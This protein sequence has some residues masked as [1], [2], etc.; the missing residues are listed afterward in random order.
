[1]NITNL[2]SKAFHVTTAKLGVVN[3]NKVNQYFGRANIENIHQ[4]KS[5]GFVAGVRFNVKQLDMG[6]A[7]EIAPDGDRVVTPRENKRR[8]G[9]VVIGSRIDV[10]SEELAEKLPSNESV[11]V[12][13]LDGM[14]VLLPRPSDVNNQKRIDRLKESLELNRFETAAT[15]SGV[16]TLDDSLHEGFELN[17][18]TTCLVGATDIWDNAINA[19]FESNLAANSKTKTLA[20]G[21]E[22]LCAMGSRPFGKI[23]LLTAGIPCKAASKLNVK[24]RDLPEMHSIAGHQ[25]LNLVMLLQSM[26]W[27][28][29]LILIE[30]VTAWVDTMSCSMLT[31]VFEEQGYNVQFVGDNV[32]G[33]YKGINSND[34]GTIERRVRMA[35]LATP[36]GI[37]INMAA[38]EH[39]RTG[40][41]TLT[42]GDIRLDDSQVDPVEYEYGNHLDSDK[43]KSKGWVNRVVQDSDTK[44]PLLSADCYKQRVEDPKF[45]H[46][47]IEGK[48]RLPMPEESAALK[49]QPERLINALTFKTH[50]HIALGNGCAR[51]PWVAFAYALSFD[52]QNWF[53]SLAPSKAAFNKGEQMDL[54]F[55]S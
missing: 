43:K 53:K 50:A 28:V 51:K 7:F 47:T 4:L 16:G 9:E 23:D 24:T 37:D 1:M 41:S 44:T 48:T 40:P 19:L 30:N 6:V 42:V 46:Q 45:M 20:I 10:R 39:L 27:D 38:M 52:L 32:D 14:L 18:I 55:A 12:Y 36:K 13:Y 26:S 35:M 5:S 29:P 49:G 21:I 8:N 15:Y 3:K 17:G 54:L 31:R 34:F 33:E 25:V 22:Q 2:I 11:V